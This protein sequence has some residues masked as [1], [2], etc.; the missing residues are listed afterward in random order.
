MSLHDGQMRRD[1]LYTTSDTALVAYLLLREYELLGLLDTGK[2]GPDGHPRL[3]F[4][5]TSTNPTVL[6]N[7]LRDVESKADEFYNSYWT[8]AHDPAARINVR[9][10]FLNYRKCLYSARNDKPLREKQ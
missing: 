2:A 6:L 1:D 9:E 3:E 5:L 8:L 7:M 10:Y 4:A